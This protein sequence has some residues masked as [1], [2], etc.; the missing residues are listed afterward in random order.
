MEPNAPALKS[1]EEEAQFH[2]MAGEMAAGRQQPRIAAQEF[3]QALDLVPNPDL[4]AR[5]T[6]LALAAGDETLGLAAARKWLSI[7]ASS[8][9]AREIITR[10]A[11][12]AGLDDEAYAQCQAIVRDHPGGN[13]DGFRHVA[14]LLAQEPSKAGAGLALMD[15][16]VAQWPKLSGAYQAQALLALRYNKTDSAEKAAREALRLQPGSKEA[17]LLLVGALVKKGDVAG[18]D[19]L[20]EGLARGGT[21]ASDLRLGYA[22]LLLESNQRAAA[23]EQLDRLLKSEP[24]NADAQLTLGLALLDDHK[25]EEAEPHFQFLLKKGGERAS[26]A[27]YY[28]G[29][30]AELRHQPSLALDH[31]EKVS[32]GSQALDASVRRAAMLA[33]LGRIG[34]ARTTLSQLRQ[35]FPPLADRFTLAE[36]EILLDANRIDQAL[37]L[38]NKALTQDPDDA[39]LLYSR[40]LVYERAGQLDQAEADL[41]RILD[42]SPDDARALNALGYMLIVH[43]ER[44]EEAQKLIGRAIE[45]T[46]DEPAVIDSLGWL[47]YRQGRT[48]EALPLLQKAYE[49]FPDPEVAAHLGEVLWASGDRD[50]ARAVWARAS[51]DDPDNTALRDTVKRLAQ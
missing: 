26:D 19:Q 33:K 38:Y 15:R 1:P 44:L 50:R 3:L 5:A 13:G 29:R 28:L 17:S 49:L 27:H 6:A 47:R 42:K 14:L 12:R 9:E 7:D 4:A 20:M 40:S 34:E 46:P 43:S 32:S 51:R 41:R 23:R 37:D 10:L 8:L 25:P 22:R 31:Y 16:L 21:D 30:I 18:A 45:L 48:Q 24:N 2:V 35:Q 11:L 39:D 36:G